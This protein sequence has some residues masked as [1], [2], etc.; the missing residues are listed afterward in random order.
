MSAVGLGTM[1]WGRDTDEHEAREQLA[2]FLE[3]GGS[4]LDTASSFGAGA[5]ELLLGRL[6]VEVDRRDVVICTKAGVHRRGGARVVDTSRSAL[7]GD[8]DQS[9]M[10]LRTDHVDLFIAQAWDPQVPLSETLSAL[11]QVVSS[12]RARYVGVAGYSAWQLARAATMAEN[13][14][15]PLVAAQAEWSLLERGVEDDLVAAAAAV[16]TGVIGWACLGRGVLTGKYRHGTPPDS[17]AASEHFAAYVRPYL[18]GRA[19]RIVEAVVTAAKGLE[20]APAEVAL[21]WARDAAGAC[22]T[23]VGARTAHQL[24]IALGS[25]ELVLP[26]AIRAAL[27][28]VSASV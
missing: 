12:G 28:D 22:S 13:A 23:I 21:A 2:V 6:L 26:Q 1:M 4:L 20:A 17:R 7:L 27:D 14:G 10:R 24:R 18:G 3:A 8:L 25:E 15:M 16:G 5:S 9:L 19:A 11:Q